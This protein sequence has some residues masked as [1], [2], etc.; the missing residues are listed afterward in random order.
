MK[1][2]TSILVAAL[3][4]SAT[5][6][7]F[8]VKL[9]APSQ[10]SPPPSSESTNLAWYTRQETAA[11]MEELRQAREAAASG[12]QLTALREDVEARRKTLAANKERVRESAEP[13]Q[14]AALD[15]R[16]RLLMDLWMEVMESTFKLAQ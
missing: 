1:L 2:S 12:A 4:L 15:E 13:D 3:L 16:D 9:S 7:W 11:I 5:G 6:I 8:G 14:L 10:P